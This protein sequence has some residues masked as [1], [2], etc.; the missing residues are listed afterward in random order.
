M[1]LDNTVPGWENI[2]LL[3]RGINT[4]CITELFL[5]FQ[6]IAETAP[7]EKIKNCARGGIGFTS[8][9]ILILSCFLD[10]GYLV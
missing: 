5:W 4:S 10:H 1:G 6:N 7:C 9:G 3:D 2:L 8:L